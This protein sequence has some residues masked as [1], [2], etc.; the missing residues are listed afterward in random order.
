MKGDKIFM[1][2]TKSFVRCV[3]EGTLIGAAGMIPG[4]SGGML[5]VAFGIYRK[6]IDAIA[7]LLRDF[8]TNFLFLLPY[9]MGGCAGILLT[10]RLLQW[11]LTSWRMPLMYLLIG[12]VLGGIPALLRSAGAKPSPKYAACVILGGAVTAVLALLDSSAV[13]AGYREFTYLAAFLSGALI[14]VGIVIPGV[15]TSFILMYIGWYEPLL[16]AFNNLQL[17]Y[18]I[19]AALGA[20][21]VTILLVSFV[22]KMFRSHPA[23]A[24]YCILGFLLGTV[25]MIFPGFS[26]GMRSVF[27]ILLTI[28]GFFCTLFLQRLGEDA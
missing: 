4:A 9:G 22:R 15:S 21:M 6:A 11:L 12:L 18:L 1:K 28:A 19:C 25:V 27:H 3:L 14:T 5:A 13:S 8:K 16:F 7:G 20:F 17:S 2:V 10:A 26:G 24:S 23:G